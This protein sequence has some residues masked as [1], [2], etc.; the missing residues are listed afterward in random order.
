MIKTRIFL[1]VVFLFL[2]SYSG[3][4]LGHESQRSMILG[5]YSIPFFGLLIIYFL[6]LGF[7]LILSLAPQVVLEDIRRIFKNIARAP[8]IG[9]EQPFHRLEVLFLILVAVLF[10]CLSSIYFARNQRAT[11]DEVAYLARAVEIK[12]RGGIAGFIRDVFTGKYLEANRHPLYILVLSL[13]GRRD[14]SFFPLGK[15]ISLLF[16]LAVIFVTY[17]VMRQHFGLVAA[18]LV[19]AFMSIDQAFL[20]ANGKVACETLLVLFAIVTWHFCTKPKPNWVLAGAF[21]GLAYLTKASGLFLFLAILISLFIAQKLRIFKEKAL[22]QVLAAFLLVAF[23]LLWRNSLVFK[24]PVYNSNQ[25]AMWLDDWQ[26]SYRPE[27][28]TNPPNPISYFKSHSKAE[29]LGRI[30]K[31]L[32]VEAFVLL[33]AAGAV[34]IGLGGMLL[35]SMVVFLAVLRIMEDENKFRRNYTLTIL[36][37]LFV[38][39]AWFAHIAPA[40][41]YILPVVPFLFV[42]G[43]TGLTAP[44]GFILPSYP[45]ATEKKAQRW[46]SQIGLRFVLVAIGI[47]LIPSIYGAFQA[48]PFSTATLPQEYTAL[49]KWMEENIEPGQRYLKGPDANFQF[50]WHSHIRAERLFFPLV[51]DFDQLNIYILRSDV[52]Y[53]II[54]HQVIKERKKALGEYFGWDEKEGLYERNQ[55]PLWQKIHSDSAGSIDFLVYGVK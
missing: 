37:M 15:M 31:G 46:A 23:P 16:G 54:T 30:H 29:A 21:S 41:R 34:K 42:Y 1:V 9:K 19:T 3:W 50:E 14:L 6:L 52:D 20:E 10:L 4:L 53:C 43:A 44:F 26:D 13:F 18:T 48:R 35:S 2:L 39:L 17:F 40:D 5:R 47:I 38:P 24:N 45:R 49:Q 36:V 55:P 27:Y 8:I 25:A 22:W 28:S 32:A 7:I 12:E 33:R 51:E 11:D